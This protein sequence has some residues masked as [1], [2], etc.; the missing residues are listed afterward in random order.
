VNQTYYASPAPDVE[1]RVAPAAPSPFLN[2]QAA[3]PDSPAPPAPS[4]QTAFGTEQGVAG[5]ETVRHLQRIPL[6]LAKTPSAS[7][8]ATLLMVAGCRGTAVAT[9]TARLLATNLAE[10]SCRVLFVDGHL[11]VPSP[12]ASFPSDGGPGLMDLMLQDAGVE[13]CIRQNVGR[14]LSV[15]PGGRR[16]AS[17]PHHIDVKALASVLGTLRE[18]FDYVIIDCPPVLDYPDAL[19]MAAG[20]DAIILVVSADR[21]SI[22]DGVRAKHDLER[23]G[24]RLVGVIFNRK[25]GRLPALRS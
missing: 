21:T 12:T 17:A 15:L 19:A 20:V 13:H 8:T 14:G 4:E 25:P 2:Q 3:S 5:I 10:T 23:A 18:R 7:G 11:S 9:T 1:A 22:Q 6:W 16:S 24:G